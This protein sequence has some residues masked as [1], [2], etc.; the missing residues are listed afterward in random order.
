M[1][2][3]FCL[4]AAFAA[5]ISLNSCKDDDDP[6]ANSS[7]KT[8][9][10]VITQFAGEPFLG[11]TYITDYDYDVANQFLVERYKAEASGGCS[12]FRNGDYI[13]RNQDW[14]MRDYAM[15]IVHIAANKEKDRL[16]SV[17]IVGSNP[18]VSREMI[19]SGEVQNVVTKAG[20]TINNWRDIFPIFTLDGINEKG[21]CASTNIVM[22]EDKVRDGYVAC[23]GGKY[24]NSE[25]TSFVS[26][27][28]YILDNCES[29]EDA[30]EKCGKLHV[31]QAFTGMLSAEDNHI[32][33]SD[34]D[35][36]VVLEW[37]NDSLV[38]TKF[39]RSNDFRDKNHMP[40]IMTNFYD[41]IGSKYTDEDGVINLEELLKEHP[42]AM[43]VE[44]YELL[45]AGFDKVNSLESA[46]AL[47]SKVDYSKFYDLNSK[48]YTE[49]G[50]FC[51]LY[52]GTWYYPATYPIN[53]DTQYAPATSLVDALHK[54]FETGGVTNQAADV[55]Q[56]LDH[57]MQILD[58]GV[59][60]DEWYT[61]FTSLYDIPKKEIYIKP[62]E[63]WYNNKFYKFTVFG[64]R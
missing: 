62:Q 20:A 3:Y 47:I 9:D 1:K 19:A 21:V 2:K 35:Q 54:M 16:A 42:Y 4:F 59:E 23:T 64:D 30:I 40:A 43:G 11:E 18:F 41:C 8:K 27:T 7:R 36:T 55:Y 61:E 46:K 63:G 45:R 34:N 60:T 39:P 38:V 14:Y 10:Y 29:C 51:G 37:Y 12:S 5:V 49:N 25:K 13:G 53:D 26:L 31:T 48:W 17:N 50:A 33:V 57:K 44:R 15:L 24:P 56:S 52:G 58:S 22:H 28:R 32:F 6:V